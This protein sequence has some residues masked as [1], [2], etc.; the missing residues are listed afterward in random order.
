MWIFSCYGFYSV[1]S[2]TKPGTKEIDPDLLMVRARSRKHLENLHERFDFL[3]E[4]KIVHI[5]GRDYGHRIIVPKD[6]WRKAVDE[7]VAEQEW[8]NFKNECRKNVLEVGWD[9]VH[10][11]HAVWSDML[12]LEHFGS[13]SPW[14]Q[15]VHHGDDLKPTG[16]KARKRR[17]HLFEWWNNSVDTQPQSDILADELEPL[18]DGDYAEAM[19]RF[20][21]SLADELAELDVNAVEGDEE[22]DHAGRISICDPATEGPD[23]SGAVAGRTES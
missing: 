9:Y 11:L 14:G 23:D 17:H 16:K 4:F 3:R 6:L 7:M 15:P 10:A 20:D 22:N 18:R 13:Y 5:P 1:A 2:A 19:R 21:E 12:K 8:D